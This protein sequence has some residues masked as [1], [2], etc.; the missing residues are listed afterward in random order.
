MTPTIE[1]AR[2]MGEIGGTVSDDERLA[3]EAWM[4][5]H[6]WPLGATWDGSGYL[7]DHE[8]MRHGWPDPGAMRT[9]QLWAAWR[10]RAALG[11]E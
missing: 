2:K 4:E 7:S 5:G 3:F 9:R 6:C 11:E 1:A 10:D 8:R